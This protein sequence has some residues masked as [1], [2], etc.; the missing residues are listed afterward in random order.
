[1]STILIYIFAFCSS[2]L[3]NVEPDNIEG[4]QA[5]QALAD[6][7]FKLKDHSMALSREEAPKSLPC[8]IV[9]L[10]MTKDRQYHHK[11]IE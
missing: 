3:F 2:T 6:Y 11:K 1:M 10:N 7:L 8:G 5:V 4:F 9:C